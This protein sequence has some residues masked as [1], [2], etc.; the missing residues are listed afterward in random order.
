MSKTTQKAIPFASGLEITGSVVAHGPSPKSDTPGNIPPVGSRLIFQSS[1]RL[2]GGGLQGSVR[3]HPKWSV[4]V[5]PNITDP[6]AATLAS[7]R[8][9]VAM[10]LFHFSCLAIPFPLG[11]PA[12]STCSSSYT[13]I[14]L[15]KAR[16]PRKRA[17]TS[18]NSKSKSPVLPASQ[19][20]PRHRHPP[21]SFQT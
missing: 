13:L 12:S 2:R 1:H 21:L 15:S 19:D 16:R 9:T 7:T 5:P 11:T 4:P 17:P 10:G 18:V 14:L 6:K 8:F 20:H 3:V